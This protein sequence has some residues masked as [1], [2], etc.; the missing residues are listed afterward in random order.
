[1]YVS[2]DQQPTFVYIQKWSEWAGQYIHVWEK[3]E[4]KMMS[5]SDSQTNMN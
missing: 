2:T 3:F 1:M 4:D 5:K